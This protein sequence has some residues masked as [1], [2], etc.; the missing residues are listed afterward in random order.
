M[1]IIVDPGKCT[2]CKS[3]E[4]IC[5]FNRSQFF[6]PKK[7]RIKVV[8][9]DYLGFSNP[10]LCLHCK[11]PRCVEVCPTGALSQTDDET[12]AVDEVKCNGCRICVDECVIGAINFDE[13]RGLPLICDLCGGNP[14]CVKWCHSGA[15]RV[16]LGK[17][18]KGKKKLRF[19]IIRAKPFLK[20]WGIREDVLEWYKK[21]M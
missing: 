7:A 9:L 4:L 6:N 15:L 18:T 5:Y 10:V 11:R 19:T 20:K 21:F 3:C 1:G 8:D 16:N 12:I 17:R 14:I 13:H 2:G